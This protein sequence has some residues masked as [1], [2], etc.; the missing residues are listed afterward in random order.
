LLGVAL[1]Q[2]RLNVMEESDRPISI[3]TVINLL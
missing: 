1:S 3:S 2:R